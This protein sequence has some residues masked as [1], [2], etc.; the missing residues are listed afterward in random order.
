VELQKL[1]TDLHT[2]AFFG[3]WFTVVIDLVAL[4]MVFFALSGVWLW[5]VPWKRKRS[6]PII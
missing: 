5:Y 2:G 1:V 3:S 6:I 4:S